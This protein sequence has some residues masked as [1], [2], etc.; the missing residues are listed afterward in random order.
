MDFAQATY[1]LG[2][3]IGAWLGW[4]LRGDFDAWRRG[5]ATD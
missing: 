1:L 5:D 4:M 2:I 3:A